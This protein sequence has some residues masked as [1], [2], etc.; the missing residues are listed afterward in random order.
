MQAPH[1]HTYTSTHRIT[2]N[3][4][5][6]SER[7]KQNKTRRMSRLAS[8]WTQQHV[9]CGGRCF[10][11]AHDTHRTSAWEPKSSHTLSLS[12]SHLHQHTYATFTFEFLRGC[13][14]ITFILNFR[15][16]HMAMRVWVWVWVRAGT[17]ARENESESR[18]DAQLLFTIKTNATGGC[19]FMKAHTHY[20]WSVHVCVRERE[21]VRVRES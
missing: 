13:C 1:T 3:G 10:K 20:K 6:K 7:C 15:A 17:G 9:N 19:S 14:C 16:R 4:I 21:R 18:A 2:Q 5:S 12:L 11:R 8:C